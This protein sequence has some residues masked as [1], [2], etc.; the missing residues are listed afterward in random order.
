MELCI[1]CGAK[2]IGGSCV[3]LESGGKRLLID[4]GL[5]L[6]A[7]L[8][9]TPLPAVSGLET[10]DPG[11]LGIAISHAHL[12]HYGLAAKIKADVPVLISDGALRILDAA[13]LFFS[14]TVQFK[15]TIEIQHKRPILLGPFVITPYL[16]DHSAYDAYGFLVEADGKRVF[17]TGDFRGH[18]RKGKLLEWLI[19]HP[20]GDIDVLLMEG[21][22]IG[23]AGND[24]VYPSENDLEQRLV[25]HFSAAKGLTLVWTSGQNI[26][27]LVTVYRA[28]R[29][30]GKKFIV[31]L[32]TA[33]ILKAIG[34]PSLPQPGWK[35]F[36]IYVPKF[37]RIIIKKQGLFDFAR[38]FSFCRVYPEQLSEMA[39]SS[40]MLFR[41]SMS[42]ELSK[43]GILE[44]AS[45]IYS[46]WSGY[47]KDDRYKWFHAWLK[48]NGLTLTHC[49]T[50]GHAPV[51]DLQ[52]LAKAL[53]PRKIVPIHSFE[54]HLY[55]TLFDRVVRH[56][57]GERWSA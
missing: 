44:N 13:R 42:K 10:Y 36:K 48:A 53:R 22:T 51:I 2:Q 47:L 21:S 30:A 31:D 24:N 33:N 4:I 56:Q 23:R 38:S 26:D 35:D 18:G 20:P 28:C 57:D 29:Q 37:Q 39:K 15:N 49:H 50:S 12:D 17:Y 1:H 43:E 16:M 45:L 14:D 25:N 9:D 7:E 8:P 54:P 55:E 27:R 41:P 11:L 6:D 32:Y 40:V 34:N 5:P 46:L 3:E 19:Q 52:R